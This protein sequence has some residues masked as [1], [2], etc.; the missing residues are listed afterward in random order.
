MQNRRRI[1]FILYTTLVV[2][3][4]LLGAARNDSDSVATVTR[5]FSVCARF[6][7]F[8]NLYISQRHHDAP[9]S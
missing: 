2:P 5:E 3:T 4:R 7:K 6:G 9:S 1:P 8:R